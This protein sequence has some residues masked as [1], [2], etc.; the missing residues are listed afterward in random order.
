MRVKTN[1]QQFHSDNINGSWH[2]QKDLPNAYLRTT[3][4]GQKMI[5]FLSGEGEREIMVCQNKRRVLLGQ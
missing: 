4:A 5:S 2:T 3:R 1:D